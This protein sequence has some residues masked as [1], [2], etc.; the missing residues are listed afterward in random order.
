MVKVFVFAVLLATVSSLQAQSLSEKFYGNYFNGEVTIYRLYQGY[1]E[2]GQSIYLNRQSKK[3]KAKYFAC[4]QS[5]QTVYERYLGWASNKKIAAVFSGAY[6]TGQDYTIPMGLTIDAGMVI[7]R[8]I[9]N[10]MDALVIVEQTGGIRIYDLDAGAN[11]FLV[12]AN[13]SVDPRSAN[14]KLQ[15]FDWAANEEATIFQ[16]NLLVYKNTLKMG[17][18]SDS[19]ERRILAICEKNGNVEHILFN[20]EKSKSLTEIARYQYDFLR[21][22]GYSVIGMINMDTGMMNAFEMFNHT[23]SRLPFQGKTDIKSVS[24]LVVYYYE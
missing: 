6:T 23:G 9:D 15:L 8:Q 21:S 24:N 13:T 11:L 16:T 7:N 19:A 18:V 17:D 4:G 3:L 5:G 14:G 22:K 20:I 10:T 2:I 12:S 1:T